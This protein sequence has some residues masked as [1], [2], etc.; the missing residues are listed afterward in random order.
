MNEF[1]EFS[2]RFFFASTKVIAVGYNKEANYT[3]LQQNM[4]LRKM[5]FQIL[6]K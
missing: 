5:R 1:I 3:F 4:L 6:Q 2:I